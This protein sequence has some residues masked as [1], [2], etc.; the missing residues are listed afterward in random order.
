MLK[1]TKYYA[2]LDRKNE[3]K[4]WYN[5]D[6]HEEIPEPN[7][8]ATEEQW[9]EA[10]SNGFNYYNKETES[11]EYKDFRTPE[12]IYEA[13][14]SGLRQDRDK[15]IDDVVWLLERHQQEQILNIPT[16]LSSSEHLE[17]LKYI[18]TLRD[19]P[20]QPNFPNIDLPEKPSFLSPQS[21]SQP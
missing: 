21:H 5:D 17:L 10:L 1:M 4:G 9:Q 20:Q 13:R 11:L 7:I 6:V 19:I 14:A 12:E 16:T 8:E 18:Q 2:H 3:L 15:A